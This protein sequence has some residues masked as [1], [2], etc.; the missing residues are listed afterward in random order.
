MPVI[1]AS[2][3]NELELRSSREREVQQLAISVARQAALEMERVVTGAAGVL[4]AIAKAPVVAELNTE[5]CNR[6][7]S[8]LKP[9]LP[10]FAAIA[11][12]DR[13]GFS[14]C[15]SDGV[16]IAASFGD[17]PYFQE[18]LAAKGIVVMGEYTISRVTGQST[19]PFALAVMKDGQIAGVVASS[20]DL[21]WLAESLRARKLANNASL[22]IADRNGTI[23]A[24]EP[25]PE[26]FVGT[27][28]PDAY[29]SLL[30][31][32]SAGTSSVKSQDG[33]E[34][35]LGYIPVNEAPIGLYISAGISRDDA[36]AVVDHATRR[37]LIMGLAGAAV[38]ILLA[39]LSG[40][41]LLHGPV[42]QIANTLAARRAG[43]E[44]RRTHMKAETGDIEALGAE[45][46][47][48]MDELNRARI[49]RESAEQHR[50]MLT[51]ELSHRIKNL[52]ATVQA[53]A[54]QTFRDNSDPKS[55]QR[56][57]FDRLD[58]MAKA[59]ALLVLDRTDA[60]T[61]K[62]AI[63]IS[64]SVFEAVPGSRFRLSGPQVSLKPE[65]AL[66]LA[67]A[68]HELSTNAI[69]YGALSV[70]EGHVA[71]SWNVSGDRFTLTWIEQGGPPAKLP[72]R[73]GFGS[74]M[75]E[76]VLTSEI[77]GSAQIDYDAEGLRCTFEA[78]IS[79]LSGVLSD[80]LDGVANAI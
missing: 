80:G 57:F 7:L 26:R 5:Q 38:A 72:T 25:I 71:I 39:W 51:N 43:D 55:S 70:P 28:I 67:M 58:A 76:R 34:R 60:A 69:K 50:V 77:G 35:I 19:L 56:A 30:R 24:R 16:A 53:I 1:G 22:T 45:I 36:F 27:K 68:A 12:F 73:R 32:Q 40:R 9:A 37:N 13:E 46:D 20:I 54:S 23:I 74:K 62:D 63:A 29:M 78:P 48:Y 2:I 11:V 47:A 3:Y 79:G 10:Q 75:I 52:L 31:A 8:D 42:R 66:S 59:Q 18:A 64:T 14:R 49:E 61:V 41:H 65:A 6:Y 15:R 17:R 21:N 4:Q 44:D 33:T